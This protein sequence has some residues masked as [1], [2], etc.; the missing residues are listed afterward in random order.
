MH[1]PA[2]MPWLASSMM[3]VRPTLKMA[4]WPKLSMAS[5]D[6]VFKDDDS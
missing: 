5:V 3:A 6:V 2:A 4:L 1:S